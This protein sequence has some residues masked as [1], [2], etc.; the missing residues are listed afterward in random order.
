MMRTRSL[1]C[2]ERTVKQDE[3]LKNTR[4]KMVSW[5]T[6]IERRNLGP[7]IQQ[8][9]T[10][11]ATLN[12]S[13]DRIKTPPDAESLASLPTITS[14]LIE[15]VTLVKALG[16]VVLDNP[17]SSHQVHAEEDRMWLLIGITTHKTS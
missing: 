12:Q 15:D 17:E 11:T 4:K 9:A 8:G 6:R 13:G 5:N 2:R 3:G 14:H 16:L 1:N 10:I 7:L